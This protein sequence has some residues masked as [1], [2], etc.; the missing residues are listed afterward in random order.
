MGFTYG[1]CLARVLR[2]PLAVVAAAHQ[3]V[4]AI[5]AA[6]RRARDLLA[7]LAVVAIVAAIIAVIVRAAVEIVVAIAAFVALIRLLTVGDRAAVLVVL[8]LNLI[9]ARG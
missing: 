9:A 5:F 6:V 2:A 4:F 3:N 1:D 8:A 7:H